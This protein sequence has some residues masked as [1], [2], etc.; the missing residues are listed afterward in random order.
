MTSLSDLGEFGLIKRFS[1]Q[2]LKDLPDGISGIGDDCAVIPLN[3]KEALLFTTDML[4][5]DRRSE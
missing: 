2:F 3:D 1:R 5:E 4:I